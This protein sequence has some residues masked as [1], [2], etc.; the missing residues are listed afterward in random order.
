LGAALQE[1]ITDPLNLGI[2]LFGNTQKQPGTRVDFAFNVGGGFKLTEHLNLLFA[3]GRDIY[4]DTEVM[5]YLGLQ[6]L[7]KTSDE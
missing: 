2:E 7:A 6:I 5:F 1:D 4:G 3:G